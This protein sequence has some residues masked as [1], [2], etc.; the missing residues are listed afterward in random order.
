M[1][2]YLLLNKKGL[3]FN[4]MT[5]IQ[6]FMLGKEK[7]DCEIVVNLGWMYDMTDAF[8]NTDGRNCDSERRTLVMGKD[9]IVTPHNKPKS[10]M[11]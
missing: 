11:R 7:R 8:R 4:H 2:G 1:K 9:S 10:L 3:G 6:I 5:R